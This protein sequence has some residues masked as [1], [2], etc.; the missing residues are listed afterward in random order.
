MDILYSGHLHSTDS[1]PITFLTVCLHIKVC[2]AELNAILNKNSADVKGCT[3]YVALFPCNECAK[4]IIQSGITEILN[5]SDKH[6]DTDHMIASRKLLDMAKVK[7]SQFI[8]SIKTLTID[9]SSIDDCVYNH[10]TQ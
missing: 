4:L 1:V 5:V 6:H 9:F 2:H 7:Y 3:I 10:W 8:P